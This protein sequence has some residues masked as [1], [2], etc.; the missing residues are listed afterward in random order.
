MFRTGVDRTRP[1]DERSPTGEAELPLDSESARIS[2]APMAGVEPLID[3]E[4]HPD[5]DEKTVDD[6]LH[7][8]TVEAAGAL[9]SGAGD[10][11]PALV[12]ATLADHRGLGILRL[13]WNAEGEVIE[14]MGSWRPLEGVG[15][16]PAS[17]THAHYAGD[18]YVAGG[19]HIPIETEVVVSGGSTY[20]DLD[21]NQVTIV[22][23][24]APSLVADS[25]FARS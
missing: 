4:V 16:I 9:G 3:H 10:P 11:P 25:R 6:A 7:R 5:A 22:R 23:F 14:T 18:L 19:Q 24:T 8:D 2:A 20:V 1:T 21:D 17:G 12:P 15:D 13:V